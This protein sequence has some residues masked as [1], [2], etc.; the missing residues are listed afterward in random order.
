[1][2]LE[3][4]D[5]QRDVDIQVILLIL[6]DELENPS[7]S[8]IREIAVDSMYMD[9]FAFQTMVKRLFD[10]GLLMRSVRKGETRLDAEGHPIESIDLSPEGIIVLNQLRGELA[11][12]V[13]Q[14]LYER[15]AS[16][17]SGKDRA[18]IKSHY[19]LRPE[20]QYCVELSFEEAPYED[21]RIQLLVRDESAAQRL[22]HRWRSE[23]SKYYFPIL[24]ILLEENPS[25][26]KTKEED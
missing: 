14:F 1:M 19:H 26:E 3:P 9:Y 13:R 7:L 12:G 20:G 5:I 22:C 25:T 21:F 17:R 18:Q 2:S 6:A 10:T 8:D 15:I 16:K 11:V 24:K 23:V 4:N